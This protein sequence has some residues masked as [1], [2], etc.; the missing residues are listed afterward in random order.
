M[1]SL[2]DA[3]DCLIS[4]LLTSSV[5]LDDK[6]CAVIHTDLPKQPFVLAQ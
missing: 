6:L 3:I 1:A 4:Q 5:S 2:I